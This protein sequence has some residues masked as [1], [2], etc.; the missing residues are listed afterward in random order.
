MDIIRD[1]APRK[2]KRVVL[3]VGGGVLLLAAT[4]GL[5]SLQPAAPSVDQ[6]TVWTDTVRH[7]TMVRAVRGP[8]TLVPEQRRWITAV[9][10]GR[11]EEILSLPGTEVD[12]ASVFLRLSNP[13]V[14]V[15]LLTARQQL[16]DAEARLVS[17][18]SDLESRVLQQE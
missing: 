4:F 3:A 13:D 9:T 8:G 1:P 17:L 2:R 5:R 6:N 14:E 7:G 12:S 16:S 18:R 10:S 11:V 15:Q